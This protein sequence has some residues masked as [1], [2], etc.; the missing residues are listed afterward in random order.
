MTTHADVL[1]A[2][3]ALWPSYSPEASALDA[4]LLADIPPDELLAAVRRYRE[5]DETGF[6]PPPGKLRA[7]CGRSKRLAASEA[8][9]RVREL[10]ARTPHA[11]T[12]PADVRE[13]WVAAYSDPAV[14]AGI[15]AV[16]RF[17]GLG[18]LLA[19]DVE[20]ARRAFCAAY[21]GARGGKGELP[22]LA[23]AA[24]LGFARAKP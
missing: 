1:R 11:G 3:K 8:W 7:L 24:L 2:L 13:A 15:Q 12:S 4:R 10:E 20:R 14:R 6:P 5:E 21:E 23:P 9:E 17:G 19:A 18:G 22:P 16:K